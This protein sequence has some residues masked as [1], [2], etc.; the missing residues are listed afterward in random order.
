MAVDLQPSDVTHTSITSGTTSPAI[1][2]PAYSSGDLIIQQ[3]VT[4]SDPTHTLPSAGAGSETIIAIA[5]SRVGTVAGPRISVIYYIATSGQSAGSLT[6]GSSE[7]ETHSGETVVVPAGEFD[8]DDP[9][10]AISAIGKQESS[11]GSTITM[12]SFSATSVADGLVV[13]MGGVDS[14]PMDD[15]FSPAGW[16]DLVGAGRD[17]GSQNSYISTRDAATTSSETIAAASFGIN[18]GDTAICIGYVIRAGSGGGPT[19]SIVPSVVQQ[20][21]SQQ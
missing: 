18:S 19:Q 9:I 5:D 15:P 11:S 21:L 14:D 3:L 20:Y 13:M 8:A 10:D 1:D 7:S 16:T 6:W 12:P 17:D 2:Y 4:D